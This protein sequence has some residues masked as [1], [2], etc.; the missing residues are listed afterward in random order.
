MTGL[1]K[2]SIHQLTALEVEPDAL[3]SLAA[4]TGC[5]EVSVFTRQPSSRSA[6]PLVNRDNVG[7]VT[8]ALRESGVKIN[9]IEAFLI[10]PATEVQAFEP[11]LELGAELGA[12][13]LST[14]LFDDDEPRLLGNLVA[15][16]DMASRLGLKV[17]IEFMPLTPAWKTL[18]AAAGL[19]QRLAH[20]NLTLGIDILHLVR[21]GGSPEDVARLAPELVAYAQLCDGADLTV[22]D[23]YAEEAVGNRLT[24]GEGAFPLRALLQALPAGTPLEL[25]IPQ[26]PRRP[27]LE[28]IQH[29]VSMTRKLM[30]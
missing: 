6:F 30:E 29:A 28:R 19:V 10:T 8:A 16:C 9:N 15:L 3:V 18:P 25:E 1:H 12:R 2:L 4:K 17:A 7:L 23:D 24:P 11:A 20:P 21:S 13:G 14:Q 26:P 27:P 22:T 5:Q